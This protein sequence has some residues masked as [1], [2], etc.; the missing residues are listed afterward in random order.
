MEEQLRLDLRALSITRGIL[1]FGPMRQL[2]QL[3]D[4][5]AEK[6]DAARQI[7]AAGAYAASLL[8]YD[9]DP[10]KAILAFLS[11]DRN[12]YAE[13]RLTGLDLPELKEMLDRE[14]QILARAAAVSPDDVAAALGN[15][16]GYL[17]T[18]QKGETDLPH[19]YHALLDAAGRE[20]FGIY[21]GHT[22][23]HLGRRHIYPVSHPDPIRLCDLHGYER[24]RDIILRNTRLLLAGGTASNVLLYG[25]SGTGKSTTVKAVA[26]ELAPEGLRLIEVKK[27]QIRRIPQLTDELAREP[28]KF[29][30]F[31]DDL[32]FT[33][34]DDDFGSL[35]AI[36][37]GSVQSRAEN[38]VIYATSN[39]RRLI[40]ET[41]S[42]R[43]GDDIHANETV[44]QQTALSDRFG[45]TLPFMNPKK[46][47]YLEMVRKL[48]ADTDIPEEELYAGAERYALEKGGRSGRV[49]RQF[50]E[51][52]ALRA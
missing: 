44:Q 15:Y 41:F 1:G 17:P 39:R 14:L 10:A 22:M 13:G 18:W 28:L 33:Q 36:L 46:D 48:A 11:G 23:F 19:S 43:D 47:V 24:Q 49:A 12:A 25:D 16:P 40:R 27:S 2:L 20:G 4:A 42:D 32:S 34:E 50:V 37:E 29:I 5:L 35:K 31:I 26:N 52:L 51:Q 8:P 45:I 9:L 30:I 38:I 6:R 21:R 3:L 7:E